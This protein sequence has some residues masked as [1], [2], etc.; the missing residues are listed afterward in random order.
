MKKTIT[1]NLAGVVFHIEEDAY[2]VLQQYLDSIKKYFQNLKGGADIQGDIESRIAEIFSAT[3]TNGKQAITIDDVNGVVKQM[4]TVEDMMEEADLEP[5]E[6]GSEGQNQGPHSTFQD[7]GRR[8]YRDTSN[9]ILGG[10]F[11]G[12]GA[13]FSINPLWIRLIA[14]AFTFGFY[15]LPSFAGTILLGYIILWISMPPSVAV[16]NKGQFRKFFRSRKHQVV[17]GVAGGLG[18][19][20]NVDPVIFR[21]AFVLTT[22]LGGAGIIIYIVLWAITPEAKTVTDELQMQ[23]NPVTLNNIEEQIKKN[24]GISDEQTKG[25]VARALSFPFKLMA[26]VVTA[27]GGVFKVL[28]NI[29]RFGLGLFL[30]FISGIFLFVISICALVALGLVS[31]GAYNIETAGFPLGKMSEEISVWMVGFGSLSVFIP[32]LVIFLISISLM[33]KKN[34]LTP[35]VSLVLVGLFIGSLVGTAFTVI[36]LVTRFSSEG[37]HKVEKVYDL[38]PQLL[39]LHWNQAD[40]DMDKY[41]AVELQIHGT[42]EKDVKLIQNFEAHGSTWKEAR[43]N[44]RSITYNVVQ[45]DSSLIFDSNLSLEPEVPFRLQNLKM[46]LYI[47]YGQVF[48][49]DRELGDLLRHTLYPYDYEE[50]QLEGNLWRY[51]AN[52]LRCITCEKEA[53]TPHTPDEPESQENPQK[54]EQDEDF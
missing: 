19:Y 38:H 2:Q 15:F 46:D 29:A 26:V 5:E 1:I 45:Q 41:H 13:Y 32:A 52:G 14:V 33:A 24:I 22:I 39:L 31:Q 54:P 10:V 18:A 42:S 34:L 40:R 23:G 35:I 25:N 37:S 53:T 51:D 36:P 11:A 12:I 9:A 6:S 47:P 27:L 20:F 43:E 48:K 7:T 3:L 28:F 50:S 21:I 17:S 8:L 16:E 49:M 44:A 4:G 30:L